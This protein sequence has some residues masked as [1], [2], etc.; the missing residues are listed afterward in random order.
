MFDVCNKR[1]AW[2]DIELETSQEMAALLGQAP[3]LWPQW[4]CTT[5]R[6]P[7]PWWQFA[8][9][10]LHRDP[11]L[12]ELPA[13]RDEIIQTFRRHVGLMTHDP[14]RKNGARALALV[15]CKPNVA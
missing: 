7:E 5:N 10:L 3:V 12:D 15:N 11:G 13:E 1:S 2:C 14:V 4:K 6:L 9:L 8:Y